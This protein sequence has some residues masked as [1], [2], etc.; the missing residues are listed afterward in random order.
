MAVH[1][2]A[3]AFNDQGQKKTMA[4]FDKF[5]PAAGKNTGTSPQRKDAMR[6]VNQGKNSYNARNYLDAEKAFMQAISEDPGYARAHYY[7]GNTLHK[8][9]RPEDAVI[10]WQRAI[11]VDADSEVAAKAQKKLD[12]ISAKN[13]EAIKRLEEGLGGLKAR[14]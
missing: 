10:E 6:C 5:S 2:R 11:N 12:M 14:H 3:G 1:R 8:L 13:L 7:L 4:L 9:N